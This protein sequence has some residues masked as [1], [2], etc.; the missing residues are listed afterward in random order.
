MAAFNFRVRYVIVVIRK[1]ITTNFRCSV[2]H[3]VVVPVLY[4]ELRYSI[5]LVLLILRGHTVLL[6]LFV[7]V[8]VCA[9]NIQ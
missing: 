3:T 6:F 5:I 1:F 8:G 4:E 9:Y 7:R 2:S